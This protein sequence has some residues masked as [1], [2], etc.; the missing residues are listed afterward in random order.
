M[1]S[2]DQVHYKRAIANMHL[3]QYQVPAYSD[4]SQKES[5]AQP[6]PDIIRSV[7]GMISIS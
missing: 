4:L 6:K 5:L 3:D 7:F 1:Y 2:A